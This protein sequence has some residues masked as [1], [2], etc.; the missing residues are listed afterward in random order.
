MELR[1]LV[2]GCT[3]VEW[4]M[5]WTDAPV[6][7]CGVWDGCLAANSVDCYTTTTCYPAYTGDEDVPATCVEG[8]GPGQNGCYWDP[9]LNGSCTNYYN[10][11]W[12]T[13]IR[14]DY[15]FSAWQ[16]YFNEG[17]IRAMDK[18]NYGYARCVR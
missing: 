2:R 13:S 15:S 10:I 3:T 7:Y 5:D 6:G 12:S 8:E 14:T 18:N 4:N 9:A 16:P 11:Y 17:R 1:S